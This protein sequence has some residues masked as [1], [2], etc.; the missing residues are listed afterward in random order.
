MKYKLALIPALVIAL[1]CPTPKPPVVNPTS[2]PTPVITPT[3]TP[4]VT[5]C[6]V[7]VPTVGR[8]ILAK[9]HSTKPDG[10]VMLDSTPRIGRS[11]DPAVK[12]YCSTL[13]G[14]PG[15]A[16]CKANPEGSGQD[17]CD[18]EFLGTP[19]P[20]W[21]FLNPGSG[22]WQICGVDQH[23]I[24]SCDH[25]EGYIEWQGPYT[26]Q[27]LTRNGFPVTGFRVIPHGNTEFKACDETGTICSNSIKVDQ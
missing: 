12:N 10:T 11:S 21:Y 5:K 9:V 4:V 19:C 2:T 14:I 18:V 8:Y 7:S 20:V 13:T 6:P 1:G 26:G 17:A 27:C 22:A 25:F 16:D 24:A 23:P 3:P 15:N